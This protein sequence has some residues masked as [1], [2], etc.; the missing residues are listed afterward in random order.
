[1]DLLAAYRMAEPKNPDVYYYCALYELKTGKLLQSKK[2][3]GIAISLGF[4]DAVKLEN[5]FPAD[6][7]KSN[8]IKDN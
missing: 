3:M 5:D 4:K 7:L 1:M 6:Y 2:D 8:K